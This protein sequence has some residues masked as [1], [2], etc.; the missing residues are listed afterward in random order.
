MK[1]YQYQVIRYMHDRITGEFVNVGIVLYQPDS[2]LFKCKT[3]KKYS[4]LSNFFGEVN[5]KFLLSNLRQFER[6]VAKINAQMNVPI[7]SLYPDG[8][9]LE[10]ITSLILP[11]DDSALYC[12]E[13]KEG[14]DISG[15][16]ALE[17]IY[18]RLVGKYS[19]EVTTKL[20]SDEDVWR[21]VY[22]SYFDHY[23]V[24]SALKPHAVKTENDTF[25]FERAWK[26]GV[27]HCFQTLNFNLKK[28]NNIKDKAYKWS[29]ILDELATT[30]EQVHIYLLTSL[31][32]DENGEFVE[33]KLSQE[34]KNLKVTLIK[35]RQ[36]EVLA[37]QM[38]KELEAH[39]S[40]DPSALVP[41]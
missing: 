31:P 20:Q 7:G 12:S 16:T 39:N 32:K 14:I 37:E 6:E 15:D 22:K 13:L 18:S 1:K 10:S 38:Q 3:I 26:N 36:A 34:H 33:R 2:R 8:I 17:H 25:E 40:Q 9:N 35:E 21:N 24:T 19:K 5:G 27:W 11:K 30:N 41:A 4:R 28:D 23:K 29:A